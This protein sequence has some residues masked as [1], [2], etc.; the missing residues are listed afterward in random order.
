MAFL[1]GDLTTI[2]LCWRLER[3][4]G[5]AIGL[6]THDRDL[7]IDGLVHRAA[8]GMTPSAIERSDGLDPDTMDVAGALTSGAIGE[9]DLI[10]GRWDGARVALFA[11][12]WTDPRAAVAL[13]EGTIGVVETSDGGFTA[14]LRGATAVLDRPV[15][16]VT[17][18][19]CRAELGDRRCRVAMAARRRMARIVSADDTA[20]T[21]DTTEPVTN[22][23]GNGVL[24]WL[25]GA[26][27]GAESAIAISAGKTLMLTA[28]PPFVAEAG[29][30]VELIEGCD[31][32]F[33]TCRHRFDNLLNFRGEPFLPGIDLLTRYPGG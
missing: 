26:N 3:R 19:E 31:K 4:D 9:N 33:A 11:V 30:R 32:S 28:P 2:A 1:D 20:I 13:G 10:A 14:E 17:S 5:V 25:G 29:T 8:P 18:P 16:E 22:A 7:L 15:V 23:Y 12:D 24:R 27:C 21:V 6:T